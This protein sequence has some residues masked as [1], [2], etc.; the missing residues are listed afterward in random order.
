M[1][2]TEPDQEA[3]EAVDGQEKAAERPLATMATQEDTVAT[4]PDTLAARADTSPSLE[5]IQA[6]VRVL[7]S[8]H[9]RPVTGA[10]LA[11]HFGV[12]A[13]TGR[14]YLASVGEDQRT[15]AALAA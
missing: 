1:H 5:D 10:L 4:L 7:A 8:R 11:D 9:G 14:R 2:K 3:R 15:P 12:S 6:A 13:R